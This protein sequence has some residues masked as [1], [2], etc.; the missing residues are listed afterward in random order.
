MLAGTALNATRSTVIAERLELGETLWARFMGLMGRPGLPPGDGLWL[1]G[2]NGIHMFF[3]RFAIDAVFL[4][5]PGATGESNRAVPPIAGCDHGSGSCRSCAVRT[6][7]SS[8]RSA[9]STR[10]ARWSG[11][12]VRFDVGG[13]R[14]AALAGGRAGGSASRALRAH[15]GRGARRGGRGIAGSSTA[16]G[17]RCRRSSWLRRWSEASCW[18]WSSRHPGRTSR[19]NRPTGP[20]RSG[21]P[22]ASRCT[23]PRLPSSA[24]YAYWYPPVLAQ[25]LLAVHARRAGLAVHCPWTVLVVG[26]LWYLSGRNILVALALI[27]FLPVALELQV[28]NVHLVIAALIVLALRRSWL[29]WIPATALKLAPGLG[30]AVPR[31]GG[32]AAR[33]RAGG[34]RSASARRG[35]QRR[36]RAAGLERLP[37]GGDEPGL[38]VD[39]RP[40]RCALRRPARRRG[41]ARD[42]RRDG[43][44]AG[45]ARSG[46]SSRSRSRTRPSGRTRC[47]MLAG[48]RPLWCVGPGRQICPRPRDRCAGQEAT[49]RPGSRGSPEV[50]SA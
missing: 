38:G 28:R 46:W 16:A 49:P 27:A 36:P 10:P 22:R 21:L 30:L 37:P 31:G 48:G 15:R 25:V 50:I 26:C 20:R 9:P 45:S 47:S 19:T 34:D 13:I 35:H 3:M 39:R 11:D 29:F 23:T 6:A 14:S 32:P 1:S 5:K 24:P 18:P 44:A 4:G 40:A 33:G 2:T 17:G 12:L 41:R 8:C 42:R 7:S 43:V